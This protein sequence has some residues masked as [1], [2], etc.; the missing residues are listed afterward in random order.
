MYLNKKAKTKYPKLFKRGDEM[1]NS[2]SC[3]NLDENGLRERKTW[4]LNRSITRQTSTISPGTI[5]HL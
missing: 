1:L 4:G 2:S 5:N 3:L